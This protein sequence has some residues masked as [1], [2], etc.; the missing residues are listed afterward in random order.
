MKKLLSLIVATVCLV[1]FNTEGATVTG[2]YTSAG[3]NSLLS[4]SGMGKSI[5][6]ANSSAAASVVKLFNAPS[7]DL[8][9]TLAAYTNTTSYTTNLTNVYTT[10]TGISQTNIKSGVL[11]INQQ[12]VAASTNNYDVIATFTVPA[13]NTLTYTWGG[14]GVRFGNGVLVTNSTNANITFT[15]VP[16]L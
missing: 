14:N 16:D 1:A 12:Q 3:T 8:T 11:V 6:I 15:Y 5:V 9:Y 13:N 7:T 4:V 2:T 10:T